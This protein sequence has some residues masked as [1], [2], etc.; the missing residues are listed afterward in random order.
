MHCFFIY[1]I[2]LSENDKLI[3]LIKIKGDTMQHAR[4]FAMIAPLI[5]TTAYVC[6]ENSSI[7]SENQN[8]VAQVTSIT[9]STMPSNIQMA[10]STVTENNSTQ[11]QVWNS[12]SAYGNDQL[13][14]EKKKISIQDSKYYEKQYS[15][16]E[17]TD[18]ENPVYF[19]AKNLYQRNDR[20]DGRLG[21]QIGQI[22][23]INDQVIQYIP[24]STQLN[25]N[26]LVF[27]KKIQTV[28][29][30]GQQVLHNIFFDQF[31]MIDTQT[32]L[33]NAKNNV[34]LAL[35]DWL[36][37]KQETTFPRGSKCF[38]ILTEESSVP[39]IK[40]DKSLLTDTV[41]NPDNSEN[42]ALFKKE[43]SGNFINFPNISGY[44]EF[45]DLNKKYFG[46][47]EYNGVH[48]YADYY[49]SRVS[50]DYRTGLHQV[51][52]LLESDKTSPINREK[53]IQHLKTN[54]C[55]FY[56]DVASKT[57]EKNFIKI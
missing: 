41:S 2:Y 10:D 37:S 21:A 43:N 3:T 55:D 34:G 32:D 39:Y 35:Y 15:T 14:F 19:T 22:T 18:M 26:D 9:H 6:W 1:L 4:T 11:T 16:A 46:I 13:V 20:V 31:N 50:F 53:T 7:A 56:N 45:D 12:Y 23:Q 33:T 8:T 36:M 44:F 17:I 38:R 52:E 24:Y 25:A 27:T 57:I 47:V 30:Y 5:L 51:Q 49:P 42:W 40:S 54:K 48:H 28:D 29:L